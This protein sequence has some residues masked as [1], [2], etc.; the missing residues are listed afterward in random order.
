MKRIAVAL[1]VVGVIA[2]GLFAGRRVMGLASGK[3]KREVPVQLTMQDGV[4][5]VKAPV[6]DLGGAWKNKIRWNATNVDCDTPQYVASLEYHERIDGVLDEAEHVVDPDPAYSKQIA[7][8]ASDTVD[9]KIDKFNW[10]PFRD[11]TYKYK[12]CVGPDPN[13]STNCL[14]PD[15]DVWPY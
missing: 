6:E 4:C 10:N 13:P 7:R 3:G 12:I 5:R 1:I 15:V 8:T 9:G 2:V 11:K 14:D